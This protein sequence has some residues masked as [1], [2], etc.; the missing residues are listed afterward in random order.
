PERRSNPMKPQTNEGSVLQF[1]KGVN[2]SIRLTVAMVG[3]GIVNLVTALAL[4]EQVTASK[5]STSVQI[6]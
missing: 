6:H 2:S 3:A 4:H 5:F 1:G